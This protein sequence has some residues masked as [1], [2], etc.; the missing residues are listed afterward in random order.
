MKKEAKRNFIFTRIGWYEWTNKKFCVIGPK[1]SRKG[2][3]REEFGEI[4]GKS[5]LLNKD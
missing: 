1:I 2:V 3:V 4:R 5:K